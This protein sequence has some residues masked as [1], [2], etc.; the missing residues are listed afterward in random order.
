M[1][2]VFLFKDLTAY[3][4]QV[5]EPEENVLHITD[6]INNAA[7]YIE[8]WLPGLDRAHLRCHKTICV[9]SRNHGAA[10]LEEAGIEVVPLVRIDLSFFEKSCAQ[11]LI[12]KPTLD[13][14]ALHFR[15]PETWAERYLLNNP[16]VF[17]VPNLDKKSFERLQKFIAEDPWAL[18]THHE[19][20]FNKMQAAIA[21]RRKT[22]A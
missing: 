13:E 1:R 10:K 17:D 22:A 3:C 2:H 15:S 7:S 14:I 9:V 16:G 5:F 11:G 6:L 20:F 8:R 18:R 4:D 19:T 12:D 21:A